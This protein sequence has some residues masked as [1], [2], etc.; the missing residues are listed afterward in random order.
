MSDSTTSLE[1]MESR[2]AALELKVVGP[3][4]YSSSSADVTSRIDKL[5]RSTAG[6]AS[7]ND[8]TNKKLS[9]DAKA[10]AESK[11]LALR[12]EYRTIDRLLSELEIS[13]TVGP[14][15]IASSGNNAPMVFRRM[16]VLASA[17]SLKRDME[18]LARIRD[19]TS[20]GTKVSAGGSSSDVVNCPIIT[21]E[22]YNLPLDP[23][24]A[25]RL[26]RLCFRVAKLNQ[27]TAIL[28]QRVDKMVNSYGK[29]M[30][31][32]SEKMVLAEEQICTMN[33]N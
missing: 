9:S 21:S 27:S 23:E 8:T 28:S 33:D 32:L 15:E 7:Y 17:E 20:I 18:L 10:K 24:A 12:E 14:T 2:L 4:S 3:A 30:S 22:R 1:Q 5:V 31:A 26:D 25:E 19:L 13:P 29:V 16:E 11:R 6:T